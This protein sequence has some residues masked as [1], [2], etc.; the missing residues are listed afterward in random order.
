MNRILFVCTANLVRSPVAAAALSRAFDLECVVDSAGLGAVEGK[1]TPVE[2]LQQLRR[3]VLDLSKHRS[4][5][6]TQDDLRESTLIVGMTEAHRD[7]LQGMLPSAIP[8]TFTFAELVRLLESIPPL[9][10]FDEDLVRL[11]KAAHQ[12]RPRVKAGPLPEDVSDPL[13]PSAARM[14]DCIDQ[15]ADLAHRMA[16]R[17]A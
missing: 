4:R 13:G 12:Q 17:L 2:A 14:R 5:P 9:S 7:S 8:R 3:Y 6:L 15:V 11:I 16:L 1:E 10:E